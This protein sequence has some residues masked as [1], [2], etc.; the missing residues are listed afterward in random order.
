MDAYGNLVTDHKMTVRDEEQLKK[1]LRRKFKDQV[2]AANLIGNK[3]K[4]TVVYEEFTEE[5]EEGEEN[6]S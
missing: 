2:N 6:Q 1:M 4:L 3:D 5:N